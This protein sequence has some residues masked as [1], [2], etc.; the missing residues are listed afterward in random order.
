M[1]LLIAVCQIAHFGICNFFYA[2]PVIMLDAELT[3]ITRSYFQEMFDNNSG[4]WFEACEYICISSFSIMCLATPL[5]LA[6][7][8]YSIFTAC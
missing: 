6:S 3:G 5:T 1:S 4:L 8:P 7:S 2:A